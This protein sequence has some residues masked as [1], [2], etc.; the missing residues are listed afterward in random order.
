MSADSAILLNQN[1]G[2]QSWATAVDTCGQHQ[3]WLSPEYT[4]NRIYR[5]KLST[6]STSVLVGEKD[7]EGL[8]DSAWIR[9]VSPSGEI[10]S[11]TRVLEAHHD[12]VEIDDA[13]FFLSHQYR[14]NIWLSEFR[15]DLA[16]D[17]IRRAVEHAEAPVDER[18]F[19]L[20][21]DSGVEPWWICDHMQPSDRVPGFGEWSHS[22]SLLWEPE[23]EAF[24][25]LIRYWD[26]IAKV[27]RTGELLWMLG[28]PLNTFTLVGDTTLPLHG[29]MSEI[30]P[31]GMLVFD[32]RNHT[33]LP[34]RV[35]EYTIDEAN[36]TLQQ[37]RVI[38]EPDGDRIGFLGDARRLPDGHILVSWSTKGRLTEYDRSGTAVWDI[39]ADHTIG[40]VE[41]VPIWPGVLSP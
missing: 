41:W 19:S 13:F 17:V 2:T 10:Q 30:W 40:R 23:E 3:W 33:D 1:N 16:S 35:V 5:A 25:L 32:N 39:Q 29:H 9:R 22:N 27:S 21:D 4:E 12:F 7:R 6:D 36:L 37:V 15:E 31:G 11:R 24:Y 28:G 20:F 8:V 18:L 34:S 26:A 38:E 14:Q